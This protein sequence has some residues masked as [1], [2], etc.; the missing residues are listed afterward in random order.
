[1]GGEGRRGD[2]ETLNSWMMFEDSVN[3]RGVTAALALLSEERRT[4]YR[5]HLKQ[6]PHALWNPDAIWIKWPDMLNELSL[7]TPATFF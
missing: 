7:I 5:K 3:V 6:H 2:E 4:R 1:M